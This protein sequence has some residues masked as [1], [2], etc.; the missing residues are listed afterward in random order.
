[1]HISFLLQRLVSCRDISFVEY[2]ELN[3]KYQE[4]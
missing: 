1:M 4:V 3:S 2:I